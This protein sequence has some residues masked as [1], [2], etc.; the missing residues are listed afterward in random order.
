MDNLYKQQ[1][2]NTIED[3]RWQRFQA[4]ARKR[5]LVAIGVTTG[6]VAL[7]YLLQTVWIFLAVETALWLALKYGRNLKK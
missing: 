5:R 1:R 3:D 4:D 6:G 2:L 7:G